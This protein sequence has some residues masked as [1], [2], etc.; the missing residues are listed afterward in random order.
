MADIILHFFFVGLYSSLPEGYNCEAVFDLTSDG[1]TRVC[2]H[3]SV[4]VPYKLTKLNPG[5]DLVHNSE[6]T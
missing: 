1:K 3:P 2:H 4:D 5:L 6:E